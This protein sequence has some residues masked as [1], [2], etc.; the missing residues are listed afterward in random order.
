MERSTLQT[1]GLA[2]QVLPNAEGVGGFAAHHTLNSVLLPFRTAG[3]AVCLSYRPVR[4]QRRRKN[5][6]FSYH[7]CKFAPTYPAKFSF[8]KLFLKHLFKKFC[9]IRLNILLKSCV[10]YA[11]CRK[12]TNGTPISPKISTLKNGQ[13]LQ[14]LKINLAFFFIQ[15]YNYSISTQ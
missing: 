14:D 4:E 15:C 10:Y 11:F 13:I 1:A 7:T 9:K 8:L 5:L 3:A 6:N 2:S 12:S